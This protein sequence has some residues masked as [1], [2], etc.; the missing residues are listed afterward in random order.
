MTAR[1]LRSFPRAGPR[2]LLAPAAAL[3]LASPAL[4]ADGLR[5]AAGA[6]EALAAGQTAALTVYSR[7]TGAGAVGLVQ[8]APAV[9]V[10]PPGAG[11]EDLP[12]SA[13][14][15][16]PVACRTDSPTSCAVQA[17]IGTAVVLA[18]S[19]VSNAAFVSWSG[20]SSITPAGPDVPS[21]RCNVAFSSARS[22][23]ANFKPATFTLTAKTYPALTPT[24]APPYLGWLQAPTDPALDCQSGNPAYVACSGR[25]AN[26]STVVVTAVPGPLS[27]V[28]SWSGCTPVDA[29]TCAAAMTVDRTV[30]ATFG[31]ADVVVT[32]AIQGSGAIAAPAGGDVVDGM[33][34]PGDCS[35]AVVPGGSITL[36]ATPGAGAQFAGWTGCASTTP[37]CTL[38]ALLAPVAVAATFTSA[39][40]S[41][42]HGVPPPAP[43]IPS[44]A[45]GACHPGFTS[46]AVN[47]A[48]HMNGTLDVTCL[49]CHGYPPPAPHA[50]RQDCW[51]CHLGYENGPD[52]VLHRNGRVDPRHSDVFGEACPTP[53]ATPACVTCHPCI[54]R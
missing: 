20:C 31:A 53:G 54:A 45:C 51:T 13:P 2:L 11:P 30:S 29:T 50:E 42:C 7:M 25:A 19:S 49:A 48:V 17:T 28:T 8:L 34:C 16:P 22:V 27:R 44:L 10:A 37:V 26:G 9:D 4:A 36:T 41:S 47:A 3:L 32:A 5:T 14:T 33:S 46:T 21:P 40:C 12:A 43:H 52:P 6:L 38:S 23:T 15:T 18:P 39:T 1:T 35:A 24:F